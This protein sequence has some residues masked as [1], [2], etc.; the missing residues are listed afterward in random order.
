MAI[1]ILLS[2]TITMNYF[3]NTPLGRFR[4]VAIIE[5]ISYLFLL[6]IAMPVKYLFHEPALV[7]YTGWVH[8]ALF[9]LYIVTLISA[10]SNE[11][12]GFKKSFLAFLAAFVPFAT[13]ILERK[14]HRE[15]K[16]KLQT[17]CQESL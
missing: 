5:G 17:Q 8:G 11:G 6:F 2:Q 12:W 7:T 14:L 4:L 16:L 3:S 9:M 1:K 10:N 15:E 13:F